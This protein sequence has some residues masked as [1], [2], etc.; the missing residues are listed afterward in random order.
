MSR[1]P[2]G[3]RLPRA[4]QTIAMWRSWDAQ[5]LRAGRVGEQ[6]LAAAGV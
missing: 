2:P 1:L 6:D 4:L 5:A 3:P